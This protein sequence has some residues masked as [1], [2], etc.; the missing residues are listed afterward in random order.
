[1]SL[2]KVIRI[3]NGNYYEDYRI[4]ECDNCKTTIEC[5]WPHFN[6]DKN[7]THYC[8]ACSFR[9]GLIDEVEYCET[10]GGINSS[11]FAAGINPETNEIE[12]VSGN[13]KQVLK[14][15]NGKK[16]YIRIRTKRS[17]FSWEKTNKEQRYSPKYSNWRTK[18]F[19]RDNYTCQ[20]CGI[21]GGELNAHHIKSW[22]DYKNLR[23]EIDNGKTLCVYCH[24]IEHKKR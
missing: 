10:C 20:I 7:E 9:K 22:K 12:L 18:V 17:K 11:M 14:T 3:P 8:V 6:D 15:I 23:F 4:Y 19:E 5:A 13:S 2:K 1:M 24:R 21:K 16:K